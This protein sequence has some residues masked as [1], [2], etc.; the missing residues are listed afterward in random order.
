MMKLKWMFSALLGA[1][2]LTLPAA[3]ETMD[4][5]YG[6]CAHVS[7]GALPG[8]IKDFQKMHEAKINWVR[9]D[10]DW[11]RIQKTQGGEWSY[12]H[13]DNVIAQAKKDKINILPILNYDVVWARPA[14][15][16]LDLW[17]EYVR[18]TV[19]RYSKDLRYW[20]VWNEQN[21]QGFWRDTPSG[22]NY[23]PLL[24]RAYEEIKKIDPELTVLYG[25]TAGVPLSFIEDSLKAGGGKYFDAMN[26]HPYHWQGTPELMIPE[27]VDLQTLLKKYNVGEKP[28]WITE[29]GWSTATPPSLFR[30]MLPAVFERAG[31]NP[32][33]AT[34]A[35]VA[36]PDAGF[37]GCMDFDATRNL[38]EFQKIETLTLAQLKNLSVKRYPVLIPAIGEEFPGAYI[39]ALRDYVKRGGTL[40]LMSGLPFYYDIQLDGK[41]GSKRVQ[42]NDKFLKEFHIG[43]E[44]WWTNKNVPNQEKYQ[45]AAPGFENKFNVPFKPFGRFLHGRNMRSG[46]EFIPVIEAGTDN[47]KGAL[48]ALY[49]LNSELK[50]NV[51]VC[52]SMVMTET[53]TEE[54]QAEML[55]RTYLIA[56][57]HGVPRVFWYCFRSGEWD[58]TEREAHF[59]VVRKNMDSKPGFVAYQTLTELC[60]SGSTRPELTKVGKSYV[61]NWTRPDGVKTWAIWTANGSEKLRLTLQGKVLEARNH[62]GE[63]VKLTENEYVASSA[64]LYLVGPKSITVRIR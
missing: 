39:P 59:G 45:K 15:K 50:G 62:L 43:W 64:M 42:V 23:V 56:F 33:K 48:T 14:W 31:V 53:V 16:N 11:D 60:P 7:R 46:D 41:G 27:L 47:Y 9:T 44:A 8:A 36:D 52:T 18:R 63:A 57:A 26:I 17:G 54:R 2:A 34:L 55:P 38:P 20:E 22:T 5:P 35:M 4:D 30:D 58:P 61:A 13:L 6:V 29:V 10:F 40:L 28:I 51:I 24:K 49:K 25:G 12:L 21:H 1:T 32:A 3:P 37:P 19:S